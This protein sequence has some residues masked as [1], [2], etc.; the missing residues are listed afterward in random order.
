MAIPKRVEE[1]LTRLGASVRCL[2]D[3]EAESERERLFLELHF[4][5]W[6]IGGS[7]GDIPEKDRDLELWEFAVEYGPISLG[8]VWEGKQPGREE[9]LAAGVDF[10]LARDVSELVSGRPY[11]APGPIRR[12]SS[13]REPAA[14]QRER[15][16]LS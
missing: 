11:G 16:S 9:L 10:T 15:E 13:G 8:L 2:P 14:R 7:L 12:A 3:P 5:T 6:A 4:F 1:R